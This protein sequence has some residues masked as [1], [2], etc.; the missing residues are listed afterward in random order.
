MILPS[1]RR[2]SWLSR[3]GHKDLT[4]LADLGG[5]HIDFFFLSKPRDFRDERGRELLGSLLQRDFD[6]AYISTSTADEFTAERPFGNKRR[7]FF[8]GV[9]KIILS[10]PEGDKIIE[11]NDGP[12]CSFFQSDRPTSKERSATIASQLAMLR[13][14]RRIFEV[15][16]PHLG[17]KIEDPVTALC[18]L[19]NDTW[20]AQVSQALREQLKQ[21]LAAEPA[22]AGQMETAGPDANRGV[23]MRTPPPRLASEAWYKR[24]TIDLSQYAED[25]FSSVN[26]ECPSLS[27]VTSSSRTSADG[28][29]FFVNPTEPLEPD[30]ILEEVVVLAGTTSRDDVTTALDAVVEV[31]PK[32]WRDAYPQPYSRVWTWVRLAITEVRLGSVRDEAGGRIGR[33]DKAVSAE[34]WE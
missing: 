10:T 27:N 29:E 18:K 31:K 1:E 26:D 4:Y 17:G 2:L 15:L 34:G 6:Q 5:V 11:W 25:D 12:A 20:H 8:I 21:V 16:A 14:P 19:Y 24:K 28:V 30:E 13:A 7:F 32:R 22:Q 33:K 3:P 9:D 23:E